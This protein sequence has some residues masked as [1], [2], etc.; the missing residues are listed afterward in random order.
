MNAKTVQVLAAPIQDQLENLM[1]LGN[2]GFAGDQE[3]PPDQWTHTTEHDF[4]ARQRAADEK[5]KKEAENRQ[6]AAAVSPVVVV[7]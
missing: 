2:A 3:T 5:R 1:E 7:Q 4:A 6:Q